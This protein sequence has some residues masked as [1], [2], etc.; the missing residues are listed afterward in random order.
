MKNFSTI[1]LSSSQYRGFFLIELLVSLSIIL[2]FFSMLNIYYGKSIDFLSQA[3]H[4][5]KALSIASS[6]MDLLL[7]ES[8]FQ[9]SYPIMSQDGFFSIKKECEKKFLF[10]QKVPWF[11]VTVSWLEGRG[12]K[13]VQLASGGFAREKTR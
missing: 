8:R 5:Q 2:L 1:V 4:T 9:Q 3:D 13:K 7:N 12:T 6:T 10:N 11:V